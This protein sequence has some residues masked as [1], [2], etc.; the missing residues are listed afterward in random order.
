MRELPQVAAALAAS[1][2]PR[3]HPDALPKAVEAAVDAA[4]NSLQDP[5]RSAATK[6]LGLAP[7]LRRAGKTVREEKAA[8]ELGKS[9]RWYQTRNRQYAGLT[10][11]AFVIDQVARQLAADVADR[12]ADPASGNGASNRN[13]ALLSGSV[14]EIFLSEGYVDN[15][16]HFKHS[17][18]TASSVAMLG[19]SHS[20]MI[21]SYKSELIALLSR[22]GTLRV[23]AMDPTCDAVI[24]ANARSSAPKKTEQAARHQY[25]AAIADIYSIRDTVPTTGVFEFR[26]IDRM[27]PYTIYVFDEAAVQA[28]LYVWLTPWRVPSSQRPGFRLSRGADEQWYDFFANQFAVMWDSFPPLTKADL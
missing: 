7:D 26:L 18:S 27:P 1:E 23:M 2:L 21:A 6:Q 25:Q 5:E 20:R 19:F 8:E 4:V 15:S 3:S 13:S 22:G 24:E 28:E 9:R 10:P 12:L 17:M 14:A 16:E 11:A